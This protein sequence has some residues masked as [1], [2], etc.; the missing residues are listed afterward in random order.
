MR[1]DLPRQRHYPTR[2]AHVLA[3]CELHDRAANLAI[4][5]LKRMQSLEP[6]GGQRCTQKSIYGL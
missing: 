3:D 4:A 6:K 1:F 5:A 2:L